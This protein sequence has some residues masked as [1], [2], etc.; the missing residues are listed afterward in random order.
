MSHKL[1]LAI[2]PVAMVLEVSVSLSATGLCSARV[3]VSGATLLRMREH[4]P[5]CRQW[6]VGA[7]ELEHQKRL[8]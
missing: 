5:R 7:L 6:V 8:F 2:A 4:Q 3:H 1:C